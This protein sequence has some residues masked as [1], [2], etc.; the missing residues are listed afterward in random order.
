[1]A[2][3]CCNE[4]GVI[5]MKESNKNTDAELKKK[6]EAYRVYRIALYNKTLVPAE[7]CEN[8]LEASNNIHGHH[9]DYD[10]PLD[11]IWLCA[12]CHMKVH[13]ES[14]FIDKQNWAEDSF[15]KRTSKELNVEAKEDFYRK[16][17]LNKFRRI[18]IEERC[19][20]EERAQLQEYKM[21]LNQYGIEEIRARDKAKFYCEQG[22]MLKMELEK[23]YP[24]D[25]EKL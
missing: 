19:T 22:V 21:L 17:G 5:I 13:C 24:D 10:K 12:T 3:E 20:Q 7:V 18:P 14:K 25:I 2:R 6:N 15:K 9:F 11:V 4:I 1:M 23:K 8:C 16:L